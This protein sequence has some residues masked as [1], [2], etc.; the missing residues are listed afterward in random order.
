MSSPDHEKT[1]EELIAA[2]DDLRRRIRWYESDEGETYAGIDADPNYLLRRVLEALPVGVWIQD[3]GGKIRIGNSAGQR[4]WA[5]ARFVGIEQFG[6]YQGWWLDSG[7]RIE[8]EEWAAA[9][10]IQKGETSIGELIEIQCFD[11]T[12]KIIRNSALPVRNEQTGE[13]ISAIIVNEDI[14]D[15]KKTEAALRDANQGLEQRVRERTAELEEANRQ[16]GMAREVA[17]EASR[18]KSEFLANMS[19]ELR[20]PL[21]VIIGSLEL[22]QSSA[23]TPE[24]EQLLDMAESSSQRLLGIINDLLDISRI[25]A[26]KLTLEEKSFDLRECVQ[27]V[28]EMFSPQAREKG[29]LLHWATDPAVPETVNG[30]PARIGQVLVNLIGNAVKFTQQGEVHIFVGLERGDLFFAIRDTGIGIP[31]AKI[32]QL[33]QPFTQVDSSLTR[34]YGGTGLGLAISRLLLALMG[35]EIQ[36]ESALGKGSTF[37][38]TL[39]LRPS[40]PIERPTPN[41]WEG[42]CGTLRILLAEDDPATGSLVAKMIGN[43]HDWQVEVVD[44][45]LQAVQVWKSGGIDL[46]LMDLQ[47]PEMNGV[48]AIRMI[49]EME[50]ETGGHTPVIAL[51]AHALAQERKESMAAGAD[52]FLTKPIRMKTLIAAIENCLANT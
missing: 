48:A 13:I 30:D 19:H 9:R 50:E 32:D 6:D 34:R 37:T 12:R 15:L 10:A 7:K 40:Q 45:G 24:L 17:E 38:F 43:R 33:F 35:G 42:D 44:N 28:V 20:T 36:V 22:M 51:T 25:E 23:P 8:A 4:I 39:P 49:R 26:R 46:V 11:G 29:L 47:M 1:R 27:K 41:Q 16:A 31:A 2:I 21:T 5:G 14:T 3:R 52:S 18:A